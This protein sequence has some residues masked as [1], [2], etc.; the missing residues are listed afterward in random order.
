MNRLQNIVAYLCSNYPYKNEL[1][2]ARLTKLVYLADW[3]SALLDGEQLTDISWVFNHYG[4]YVDDV[5]DSA[6]GSRSFN[7]ISQ[8]NHYGSSKHLVEF[9]GDDRE[10]DLSDRDVEILDAVIEKTKL[11]YFNAF[12]DY[13][14]STYPVKASDRYAVLDL[15]SLAKD[16]S[17]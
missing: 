2:K 12:I 6:K 11:M 5:V 7:I 15:V 16:F 8:E 17:R 13:V 4:P 1:S 3:F 14:Y 9:C 10:I